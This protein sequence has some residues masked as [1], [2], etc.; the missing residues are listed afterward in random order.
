MEITSL[1]LKDLKNGKFQLFSE[2]IYKTNDYFIRVPSGFITNYANIPKLLRIFILPYGKHS[3]ASVVHDWL[4]SC[5]C[6]I[7]ISRLEADRIFLEIMEEC[8]V[9]LI[10]RITMF[11][12]VRLFGE[13][14]F[15]MM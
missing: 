13:K 1:L 8:G 5:E 6:N 3:S 12:A 9:F 11:Y 15:K 10:I 7:I 4:Y 14:R 2:Y